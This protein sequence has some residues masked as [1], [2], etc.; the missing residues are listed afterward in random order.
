VVYSAIPATF[1]FCFVN[2]IT[3]TN[4][5]EENVLFSECI[6]LCGGDEK[7]AGVAKPEKDMK[8]QGRSPSLLENCKDS[9]LEIFQCHFEHRN[10]SNPKKLIGKLVEMEKMKR[11]KILQNMQ[12]LLVTRHLRPR[13]F[14]DYNS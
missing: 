12:G 8:Q 1:F 4:R 6:Y 14:F 9:N 11:D 2:Q 7:Y 3:K 5:S 10:T 13:P